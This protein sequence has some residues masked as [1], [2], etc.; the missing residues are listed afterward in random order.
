MAERN[1]PDRALNILL[2]EDETVAAI[3]LEC[4]IEDLGHHVAAVAITP[5]EARRRMKTGAVDLVILHSTHVGLSSLDFARSLRRV[6]IPA[7]VTSRRSEAEL[8]AIG[9]IEPTLQ[10]PFRQ[11][12]VEAL[13][14]QL[15]KSLR[16]QAA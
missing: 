15:R 14:V 12:A 4:M 2:V 16:C 1:F 7:V 6:G 10:K 13:L 11:D 8:R 9:Y 3:D 5:V